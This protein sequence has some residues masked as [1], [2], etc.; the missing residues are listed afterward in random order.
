MLLA[1]QKAEGVTSYGRVPLPG[2][3]LP[4]HI[5]K[6]NILE[7]PP[8]EAELRAVIWGLQNKQAAGVSG[9]QAKHIKVWLSNVIHK[10]MEE[11]DVGLGDKWRIL[12]RFMQAIWKQ[13]SIPKQ[14]RQKI[15]SFHQR[16]VVII[17]GLV[18]WNL[19]GRSLRKL[20]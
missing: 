9:Q 7:G 10:E 12:I 3:P 16:V 1:S 13:G 15:I 8:C 6:V 20:W 17:V 5:D 4:I 11:S 2:A 18:S 19:F 14:M